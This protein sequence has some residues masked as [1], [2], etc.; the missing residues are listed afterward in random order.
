MCRWAGVTAE[1]RRRHTRS[2]LRAL[3]HGV[4]G[5]STDRTLGHPTAPD[6]PRC[7]HQDGSQSCSNRVLLHDTCASARR[8]RRKQRRLDRRL[9]NGDV[10]RSRGRS[11]P[12]TPVGE[13]R[14]YATHRGPLRT[15]GDGSPAIRG[16]P[17]RG[18]RRC[19]PSSK[20]IARLPTPLARRRVPDRGSRLPGPIQVSVRWQQPTAR[21]SRQPR[22]R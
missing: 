21:G 2:V 16:D 9:R 10:R 5:P 13:D 8:R 1:G 20:S 15:D 4:P 11:P 19:P 6:R 3:P 12:P 18:C 14:T 22:W 7:V 17:G